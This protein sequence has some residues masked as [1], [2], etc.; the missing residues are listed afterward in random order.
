MVFSN[1]FLTKE[2]NNAEQKKQLAFISCRGNPVSG[3]CACRG[4]GS[5]FE[6]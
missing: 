6:N 1:H 2:I 3:F 5:A 4:A